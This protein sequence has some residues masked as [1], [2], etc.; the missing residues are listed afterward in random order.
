MFFVR[1]E[2]HA[3]QQTS[4]NIWV[5]LSFVNVSEMNT[6]PIQECKW[7]PICSFHV[8]FP[9]WV[10]FD[11]RHLHTTLSRICEFYG[12]QCSEGCS[13]LMDINVITFTCVL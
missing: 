9:D 3:V 11:M 5:I 7:I 8:Y 1:F 10:K 13:F 6:I 4:T 2:Q 12:N